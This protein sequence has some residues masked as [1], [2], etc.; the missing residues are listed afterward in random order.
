MTTTRTSPST[1]CGK[2]IDEADLSWSLLPLP[3]HDDHQPLSAHHPSHLFPPA[4]D[5]PSWHALGWLV[6]CFRVPHIEVRRSLVSEELGIWKVQHG[7]VRYLK[8]SVSKSSVSE[9][10]ILNKFGIW[11]HFTGTNITGDAHHH[12]CWHQWVNA[13]T[14]SLIQASNGP[15]LCGCCWYL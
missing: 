9:R 4:H 1:P 8:S 3:A 2:N 15:Q 13:S 5:D 11:T 10:S 14:V 12:C 6:L 7:K